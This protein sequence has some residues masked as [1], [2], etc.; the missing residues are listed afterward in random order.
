M[1]HD[2][3][4]GGW[5]TDGWVRHDLKM[6][7]WGMTLRWVGGWGMTPRW[8]EAGSRGAHSISPSML[9]NKNNSLL[10]NVDAMKRH[11]RHSSLERHYHIAMT[12]AAKLILQ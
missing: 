5:G 7:G 1:G 9:V 6:G 4:M 2:L 3:K 12:T 10:D 11:S 8:V